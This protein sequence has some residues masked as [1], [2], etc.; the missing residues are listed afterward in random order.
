MSNFETL[1]RRHAEI[2][3]GAE[4]ERAMAEWMGY[5]RETTERNLDLLKVL[6]AQTEL[7]FRDKT[8]L[9]IGCGT[10][11]LAR[12]VAEQ[13]GCYIGLDYYPVILEMA[14]ALLDDLPRPHQSALLRGS[15][16]GL[17]LRD[18]SVDMVAAFD[19]IEHLVGGEP[20]QQAFLQ[21]IRRVL[22]PDGILLLTTPNRLHP[23]EPHTRLYGPHYLPVAL[24][25][26]YIRWRNP[27]FLQEYPTYGEI[28]LLTPWKMK[29]L[30]DAAGL[31]LIPDAPL[32][33]PLESYS[34][35]K[36]IGLRLLCAAG[37]GWFAPSQFWIS[38][39]RV[40]S[41]NIVKLRGAP[42]WPA[43]PDASVSD[44]PLTSD[45][46]PAGEA[47]ASVTSD[48]PTPEVPPTYE[49]RAQQE[50][51]HFQSVQNV[52]DLPEIFHFWSLKYIRP[53][54]EA[55]FGVSTIDD[56][57][58]KYIFQYRAE[59][60]DRPLEIVSLGAGNSD[61][62][63]QLAGLLRDRGLPDFRFHCFDINPAMLARG[64]ELASE[65]GLADHFEFLETDVG[66]W[67]PA[68][69][70]AVVMAHHSLHHIANLE[71]VF[72]A[73]RKAIGDEGYLVTCDMIGRNGHM[74]W[75]EALEIVHD[76]WRTM[77]DR[78]KYNRALRRF[79]EL[80]ENWDCSQE[81]FEGIR[82]QDILPLLVQE[83]HFE[84]F[85]AYG[86]LPDIFIDRSFGHNFDVRNEE[87]TEFI[88][89]IGALN[90]RL[91]GEGVIKPTQMMAALRGCPAGTVRCYEHWTPEFCIRKVSK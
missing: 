30:L 12:V 2:K 1:I 60:P 45:A 71:E 22:R 7:S 42:P 9:D 56:F 19:V 88:D 90:D 28:H 5:W 83:F 29:Q 47:P 66:H 77:P 11:G 40:E 55:V 79:E 52:H 4:N 24:A 34:P 16:T 43:P 74:R 44:G 38:A 63:I 33:L 46:A 35:L 31:R 80:Y 61:M 49:Q 14:Q 67:Q 18:E 3:F 70:V 51:E 21:E 75:P 62:E 78:Y 81:G 68:H 10:A 87:D 41:W 57:Y 37:L 65:K 64:R 82:A 69:P 76:I 15:G 72:A 17:P 20:W 91:I 6:S 89:R 26:R 50:V 36:R 59:H 23:F 48:S 13:G 32:G 58:L 25:D 54:L 27:S 53:K 39:C 73:V 8:L 85:I 84:S 86:N